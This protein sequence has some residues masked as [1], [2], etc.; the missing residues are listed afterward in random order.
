MKERYA[1]IEKNQDEHRIVTM[2]KV[3][4]VSSSGYYDWIKREESHHAKYDAVL[5]DQIKQMHVGH[6]RNYGA[7]RVH[8]YLKEKHY[9]CSR[10]RINR[11]MKEYDVRSIYHGYKAHRRSGGHSAIFSNALS[12]S[13]KATQVNEQWAGDMTYLKTGH[14]PLYMAAIIDLFTRKVIG[15][16][17]SR[18]HDADLVT[19]ALQMSLATEKPKIGCL[20]HSD[21]G[22]EYRS[23]LYQEALKKAKIKPSMSRA[24]TPTDNAYVE[25]FFSTLKNELVHHWVFKNHVECVARIVDYIDFYNSDRLHSGLNYMSPKTYELRNA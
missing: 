6:A 25:S 21:Q 20:Y 23:T 2:F 16:S 13:P 15:W 18:N 14:G 10:R 1:F 9:S 8:K 7:I 17:F 24:G 22:S 19:G 3:L 12:D 5:V 4:G 11:L